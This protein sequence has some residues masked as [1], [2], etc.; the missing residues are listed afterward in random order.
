MAGRRTNLALLVLLVIAFATGVLSWAIGAPVAAAVVVAHG[1]AGLGIVVLAPWKAA[2]VRR[3]RRRR[4]PGQSVSVLL[5]ALSVA[6]VVTGLAHA[7]GV[8]DARGP[9]SPIGIHVA[10]GV[11][12][13]VVGIGHVVQRPVRPRMAD[14]SRRNLLR[15]GALAAGAGVAYLGFE[16]LLRATGARGAERR[17]TGSHEAGSF[18][19]TS[20]PVTQWLDDAVPSIDASAWRLHVVSGPEPRSFALDDLAAFDD[21]VRATL[22]CTGGWYADQGWR[23]ARLDRLIGGTDRGEAQ[24]ASI[25][26]RSATGYAR[27][28][29]IGDAASLLLATEV[30]GR[31]L[32]PGHG[33]P[34]RLVA[35]MRRGFW[36]VKW[37]AE[38]R[39]D[40]TPWW[41]QPPFP[42]T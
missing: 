23:G 20:M 19:P 5:A 13:V 10:T 14:V 12:A 32:S 28:F 40:D 38:I 39:V 11:A 27:R 18:D 15:T 3:G 33:F 34:A 6:C 2:I 1:V 36:W 22:D 4:R 21:R 37:V 35:P 8:L 9:L 26:V 29:P 41:W 7:A 25:L 24:G 42:V 16:G 30:G 31:A 17:F